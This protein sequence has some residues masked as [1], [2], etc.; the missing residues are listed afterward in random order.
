MLH[1]IAPA[2]QWAIEIAG[3][4]DTFAGGCIAEGA[5]GRAVRIGR[6]LRASTEGTTCRLLGVGAVAIGEALNADAASRI[7]IGLHRLAGRA[8]GA[9]RY[10]STFAEITYLGRLA[11][12]IAR[13]FRAGEA[14]DVAIRFG[15]VA[16]LI[17]EA[18]DAGAPGTAELL[19]SFAVGIGQTLDAGR[20][21]E[22]AVWCRRGALAVAGA[23]LGRFLGP[24]A[25]PADKVDG[26]VVP[27]R[28]VHGGGD[29]GQAQ[30]E[31]EG[32]R[33]PARDAPG[34]RDSSG[35]SAIHPYQ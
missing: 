27:H 3:A 6:A 23:S 32:A 28:A 14:F 18:R 16:I 9:A 17:G 25:R 34:C 1:R 35:S 26:S 33:N 21:S 31:R 7:A 13:A 12:S 19:G 11:M 10:A 4:A 2:P 5:I 20:R 15:L 29:Q 24:A 22:L 30:A 8:I